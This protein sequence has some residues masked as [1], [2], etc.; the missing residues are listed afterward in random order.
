MDL[1]DCLG[2]GLF[3]YKME[4]RQSLDTSKPQVDFTHLRKQHTSSNWPECSYRKKSNEI[5]CKQLLYVAVAKEKETWID[6]SVLFSNTKWKLGQ[7]LA[8]FSHFENI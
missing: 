3:L 6:F 1:V 8:D 5:I 2:K 7:R 4:K